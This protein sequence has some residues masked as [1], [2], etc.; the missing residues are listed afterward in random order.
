MNIHEYQAKALLKKYNVNA[1]NGFLVEDLMD[2][3]A[4]IRRIETDVAVIKAQIHAGGRGK[5]GGVR[6]AKTFTE[7]VEAGKA[8][9]GSTLVT[10]QT[11][12]QGQK[13]RKVY[14]EEGCDIKK[15]FYL[16]V[17]L[18]RA[19]S[20]IAIVASS[21]GGV[22]IE[23]VSE[24]R[25]EAIL[26]LEIDPLIGVRA[27]H[28][29]RIAATFGISGAL[30]PGLSV[31]VHGLY[32]CFV[33]RDAEMIEINPLVVT[34][35][36]EWVALDAKMCFDDNALFRNPEI[37]SLRDFDEED[38]KEIEASAYGL[39]Y[40]ALSGNIACLVNGAGL[41]MAT[42]DAIKLS[43]GSPA[44]FLDVGGS[45]SEEMVK[46]ALTIILSDEQVEG[47]F[48]NIFGGIMKC[49]TIARGIVEAMA[50]SPK[51]VPLVVRLEGNRV[52]EGKAFLSDSGLFVA[53]ADSMDE[54]AD[55]I[56][57]WVEKGE[58]VS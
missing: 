21:E 47:I 50:E 45:A 19:S 30:L 58:V 20:G 31:L 5:A 44:N 41:A 1:L 22:D 29:R 33:E 24:E 13:V 32:Q 49:D 7:A 10:H 8:L 48:V 26:K 40:V 9:L 39:S 37:E 34:Q 27:F 43:G 6:L 57:K 12:D 55:L 42:M 38:P 17:V 15:E 3:E 46:K 18:D 11:G 56:V 16:S 28:I 4:K 36:G 51:K 52:K 53:S 23:T 14:V 35:S 25:P 54:G 2:L